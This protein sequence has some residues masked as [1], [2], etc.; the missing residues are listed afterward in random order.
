MA[1]LVAAEADPAGAQEH[2]HGALGVLNNLDG[3]A[4]H[5]PHGQQPTPFR[6]A[7]IDAADHAGLPGLKVM[8]R[9]EPCGS[10]A[11]AAGMK[12]VKEHLHRPQ[13]PRG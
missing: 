11:A 5:K 7:C 2:Y 6:S 10:S 4:G 3:F 1:R 12:A 8:Q 9:Y 13:H